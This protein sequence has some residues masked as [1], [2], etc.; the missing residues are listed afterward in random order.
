MFVDVLGGRSI[1]FPRTKQGEEF[2]KEH[3]DDSW[4]YVEY[5]KG[6]KK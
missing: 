2:G 4:L 6:N 3:H 1:G 5:N